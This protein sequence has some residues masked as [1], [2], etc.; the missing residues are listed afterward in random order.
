M[1]ITFTD[2]SKSEIV[3]FM[4]EEGGKLPAAAEALDEAT[5]GLL[6]EAANS[7]RFGGN[8]A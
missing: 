1:K 7:G 2:A 6:S 8:E 3:G 5:G 4:V